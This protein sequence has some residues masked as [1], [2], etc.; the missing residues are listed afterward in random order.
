MRKGLI[1]LGWFFIIVSPVNNA[2]TTT[3]H[4]FVYTSPSFTSPMDCRNIAVAFDSLF[5]SKGQLYG[6]FAT[7][8]QATTSPSR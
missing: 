2:G 6:C 5:G 7:D 1:L 3:A 8:D 4:P